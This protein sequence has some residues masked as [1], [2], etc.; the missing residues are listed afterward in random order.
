MSSIYTRAK[1]EYTVVDCIINYLY[2]YTDHYGG[3]ALLLFCV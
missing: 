3:R 1:T 2:Y